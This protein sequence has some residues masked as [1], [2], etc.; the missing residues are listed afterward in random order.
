MENTKEKDVLINRAQMLDIAR[1]FNIFVSLGTIHRWANE[2]GF[3]V[4]IGQNGKSLLYSRQG[5]INC[6][7]LRIKH[8]QNEH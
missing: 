3:P 1:E 2:P 5:F 6:L 7:I 4:V 8:I